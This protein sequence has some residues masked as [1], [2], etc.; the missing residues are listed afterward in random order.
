[1]IVIGFNNNDNS[2][3]MRELD[4]DPDVDS[5]RKIHDTLK[6]VADSSVKGGKTSFSLIVCIDDGEEVASY[7]D[8]EDYDLTGPPEDEDDAED[9]DD[10]D[11]DHLHEDEDDEDDEDE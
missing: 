2:H 1:M 7:S 6:K 4:V 8:G 3:F 10:A 5:A 9:D 11:P